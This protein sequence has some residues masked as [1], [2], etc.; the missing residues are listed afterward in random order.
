[1][2]GICRRRTGGYSDHE[3]LGEDRSDGGAALAKTAMLA[4]SR[5]SSL[6]TPHRLY[7][8]GLTNTVRT[9]EKGNQWPGWEVVIGI[10]VHAQIKSRKKL[11]SRESLTQA[12]SSQ[13]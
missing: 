2:E 5:T 7:C 4:R 3:R 6:R 9:F 12:N 1:M 13:S 11:F 10:E 8:T